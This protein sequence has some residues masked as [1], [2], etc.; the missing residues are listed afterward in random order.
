MDR[1]HSDKIY[2][3]D[4]CDKEYKAKEYLQ[5]HMKKKHKEQIDRH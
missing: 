5:G 3:C 1:Y 2:K 4:M